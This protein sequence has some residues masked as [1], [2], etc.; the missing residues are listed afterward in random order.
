MCNGLSVS[1][2]DGDYHVG[3]NIANIGALSGTILILKM[4]SDFAKCPTLR[5]GWQ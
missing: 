1:G 5:N 2:G 3:V 4:E